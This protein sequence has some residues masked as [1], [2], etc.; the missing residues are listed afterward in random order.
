MR[1]LLKKDEDGEESETKA[2]FLEGSGSGLDKAMLMLCETLAHWAEN[3]KQEP[4]RKL[5]DFWMK[6]PKAQPQKAPQPSQ[7]RKAAAQ[8]APATS[9]CSG[10]AA[11]IIS[12]DI[13]FGGEP[14]GLSSDLEGP[15]A[16]RYLDKK[17]LLSLYNYL[18]IIML[19]RV[20]EA[21]EGKCT[22]R[23]NDQMH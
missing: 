3:S 8:Q 11:P 6:E 12:D 10:K 9:G 22:K 18:Y 17:P 5:V 13:L 2:V 19:E 15:Q 16:G 20:E 14:S 1:V 7:S 21:Q 4:Q 23:A